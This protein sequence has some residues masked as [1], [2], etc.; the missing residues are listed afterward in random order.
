MKPFPVKLPKDCDAASEPT[1]KRLNKLL[2]DCGMSGALLARRVDVHSNTVTNWRNGH[3]EIPGAVFAY[4]A[5]LAKV[6]A[7]Q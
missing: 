4:L 6:K 3:T 2:D 1:H 7:I 5:L